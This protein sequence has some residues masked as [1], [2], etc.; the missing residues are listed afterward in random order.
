MDMISS[1]DA[2]GGQSQCRLQDTEQLDDRVSIPLLLCF[3][4]AHRGRLQEQLGGVLLTCSCPFQVLHAL[5]GDPGRM[6][7]VDRCPAGYPCCFRPLIRLQNGI[8]HAAHQSGGSPELLETQ[9]PSWNR[10]PAY[11]TDRL[12]EICDHLRGSSRTV[13]LGSLAAAFGVSSR[14]LNRLFHAV[15]EVSPMRVLRR[16]WLREAIELIR[17]TSRSI[18]SIAEDLG[19]YDRATFARAFRRAFGFYPGRLR[20]R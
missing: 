5:E 16:E 6:V 20:R 1:G 11:P 4:S 12:R 18:E 8:R 15:G 10:D 14:Q 17:T 19:Y 9:R 7:L 13:T 2:P 3:D